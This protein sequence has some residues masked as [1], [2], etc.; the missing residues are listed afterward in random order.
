MVRNIGISVAS[1]RKSCDDKLC[2]FH[3]TLAIRGKM[4]SGTVISAKAKNMAVVAREYPHPV[5]KYKRYERS[6][7]K[8]HAYIPECIDLEEGLEVKIA[9]CRPLSKT[10]SFV[11]IEVNNKDGSKD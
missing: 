3:G 4:F 9:E 6:K 7:S 10:V 2:P 8:L 5:P 11:I 1:P